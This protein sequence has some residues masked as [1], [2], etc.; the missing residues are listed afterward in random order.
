MVLE[1]DFVIVRPACE[2]LL[3]EVGQVPIS[4]ESGQ[5]VFARFQIYGN[6]NRDL[7]IR[8]EEESLSVEGKSPEICG[9][10]EGPRTPFAHMVHNAVYCLPN[11]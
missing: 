6:V 11:G 2:F 4:R 8:V 3:H 1:R 9:A 7:V 5:V 10:S